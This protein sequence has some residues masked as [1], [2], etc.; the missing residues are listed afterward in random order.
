MGLSQ[1]IHDAA[2]AIPTAPVADPAQLLTGPELLAIFAQIEAAIDA[3]DLR[4]Q[5]SRIQHGAT[6]PA[7]ALG[8][9]LD[10]Y[11]NTTNGDL[12]GKDLGHWSPLLNLRGP[13]GLQGRAGQDGQ[14]GQA[15]QRGLTGQ[16][17]QNG[18]DGQDGQ[19]GTD[20]NRITAPAAA[21]APSDGQVGDLAIVAS[22]GDLQEKTAS[23]WVTRG[24]LK[25][26]KGDAGAAGSTVVSGGAG[27]GSTNGVTL[28]SSGDGTK[29]LA[30]DGTYKAVGA[31]AGTVKSVN[32][33]QP[34]AAGN[35][36]V[37]QQF[38]W[39]YA[40]GNTA[41]PPPIDFRKATSL[42]LVGRSVGVAGASYSVV[43]ATG[44]ASTATP[45]VFTNNLDQRGITI[46]AGG[47]LVI[48]AVTYTNGYSAG[49]LFFEGTQS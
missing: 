37:N 30:N 36:V 43:S 14:A 41:S 15:G 16:S 9:D 48:S 10:L 21:P 8:N 20:G 32:G 39:D 47:Q 42:L 24:N 25:G 19:A 12:Y 28:T 38:A 40:L 1:P 35:V 6:A 7:D 13:Q 49:T 45:F 2:L 31:S 34:D 4:G 23:G 26:P 33:A 17:G 27:T 11:L 29:F 44:I 18:Q 46:P 5:G 3:L 22:T